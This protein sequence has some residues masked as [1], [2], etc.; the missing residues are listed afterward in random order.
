MVT[1]RQFLGVMLMTAATA[2][3]Q[4]VGP[5]KL[6][7]PQTEAGLPLMQALR[8][9]RSNREFAPRKLPLQVLANLLWAAFGVNR[10]DSGGRT[11]PSAHNWQEIDVYVA[12]EEGT[13]VYYAKGHTLV[14]VSG[15]DLRSDSGLQEFV[16]TAPLDLVLVANYAR[17][18]SG[19]EEEKKF[20]AAC[21]A[22]FICQN[23][24][25]CCASEGLASVVRG[26][27][28]RAELSKALG[29]KRD[30]HIVLA[31]TVGYP[32]G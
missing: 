12:L 4:Q 7:A 18:G 30:Q 14:P 24:Y 17:M 25:L 5:I 3:A 20:F 15:S 22:G 21:D 19:N 2:Q 1:R 16:G 8:T 9:R 27:V 31:Q 10:P 28:D 13:Y 11:A 26:W 32:A 6:P 29:L 23:V